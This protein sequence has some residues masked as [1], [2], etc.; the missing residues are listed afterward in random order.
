M[1]GKYF[2]E[3][4][5]EFNKEDVVRLHY[6]DG[7]I[8]NSINFDCINNILYLSHSDNINKSVPEIKVKHLMYLCE[9]LLYP[10]LD[11]IDIF[12]QTMSIKTSVLFVCD[13]I[14]E[15]G[16]LWLED[17][18]DADLYE[19]LECRFAEATTNQ[20]DELDFYIEL[21][22]LGI[23]YDMLC[24]YMNKEVANHTLQ[25]WKEHGIM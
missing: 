17:E 5:K 20:H 1:K 6:K 2:Y 9:S 25:F 21:Y 15:D 12:I 14:K 22:N 24:K 10:A 13:L 18:F 23:T 16:S 19:E 3:K 11:S 7:E 4:L 8:I